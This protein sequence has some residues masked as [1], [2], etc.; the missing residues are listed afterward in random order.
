MTATGCPVFYP[1]GPIAIRDGTYD[2]VK[3]VPGLTNVLKARTAPGQDDMLPYAVVWFAGE[4][5]QPNGDANTGA[6]EFIHTLT[7][8]VDVMV[9]A[10]DETTL[11]T[12]VVGFVE[13]IRATLMTDSTW[14][15][16]F[17]GIERCDTRYAYPKEAADIVVQAM[18]EFE[19]TFRSVWQPYVPNDLDTVAV[20]VERPRPA[21]SCRHCGSSN[22][23][24]AL[25]C[26][27]CSGPAP[28]PTTFFT[29]FDLEACRGHDQSSSE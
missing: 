9:R 5:T 15:G 20:T 1:A 19:V 7:L 26:T 13:T 11:D 16:L 14:I 22:S 12:A 4:R 10:G 18:I 17:E 6:P 21:W 27:T 8:I 25:A 23:F 3:T 28:A 24:G 29:E 2:R